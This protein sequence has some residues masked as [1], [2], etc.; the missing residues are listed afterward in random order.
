M[1]FP[2]AILDG[3]RGDS[4]SQVRAAARAVLLMGSLTSRGKN[5]AKTRG[6]LSGV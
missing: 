5:P 1:G 4:G 3:H 2:K 6:E